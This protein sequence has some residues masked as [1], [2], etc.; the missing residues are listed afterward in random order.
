MWRHCR[1]Y[2]TAWQNFKGNSV[3]TCD[4]RYEYGIYFFKKNSR[5]GIIV[6]YYLVKKFGKIW[7]I[8]FKFY[9]FAK[10]GENIL[11]KFCTSVNL[12]SIVTFYATAYAFVLKV[13]VGKIVGTHKTPSS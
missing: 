2:H 8:I 11:Q 7:Q 12:Q 13:K 9:I 4:L 5:G 6:V 1:K 3:K 10:I